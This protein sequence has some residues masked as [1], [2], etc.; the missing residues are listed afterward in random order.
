ML[1]PPVQAD[2]T[3][4]Q[5]RVELEA[6]EPRKLLSVTTPFRGA[7]FNI[8]TDTIEAED[9][10][11]GGEGI[12][13]Y[14]TT[15]QNLL[16]AYRN[17]AVDIG[18]D[19]QASNGFAVGYTAPGEW[20]DYSIDTPLAGTYALKARVACFK[21]GGT[22]HVEI[23]GANVTGAMAVPDTGPW[24]TWQ[25]V[26]S[27]PFALSS[28]AHV[29]RVVMD[30]GGY[31]GNIGDFD[32]FR[33]AAVSPPPPTGSTPFHGAP[34]NIA[35]DSIEAEDFDNGGEGVSYHDTTLQNLLGGYRNTAVDIGA[36]TNASNGFAVGYTAPGEWLDYTIRAPASGTYSLQARVASYRPGGT[37]HVEIDGANVTGAMSVPDTGP[38][39]T[40]Q[41]IVS[42]VFNVVSGTHVM[43]VVMDRGGYWGAIGDFDSFRF[44]PAALPP[45]ST[46]AI[47]LH[48]QQVANSPVPRLE[49]SAVTVGSKL[50]VFGGY[51]ESS[52]NWL[53]TKETDAYDP[54]TNTW[55]R[56]ADM[57]EG[58]TH[59]G[60]ATDGR[61]IYAAG[62]YVSNY[63]TGWQT[64]ATR[65]VWRYDTWTNQWT[66]FVPLPAARSAGGLV[67]L[68]RQ[69][70]YVDGNDI[71]R[72]G[73]TDH[74]V[75]NLDDPNPQWVAST[76]LPFSR[77][78]I[79]ATVLGGKIYVAGGQAG[80][81]DADPAADVLAWD[82]ANPRAWQTIASL[83]QPRSHA[84]A[85]V[86]DGKLVLADGAGPG[87]TILN[88]V[89]AYD[90]ATN[91][92]STVNDPLPAARLNPAGAVVDGR[93]VI[94]TG[95]WSG[96]RS[97]T[98][99]SSLV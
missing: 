79:T 69:I 60:T 27:Q 51:N 53:A 9:F 20:L 5:R 8:S 82:P 78:H 19:P 77:N 92:W 24:D 58:L 94:T 71:N 91:I 22:Y 21:P 43:R 90:P 46:G 73:T 57:P 70:H 7:P 6:L 16:G 67:L 59:I 1:A 13:Y 2:R 85:D 18:A 83:P 14:D 40:W 97:E 38:W 74:W 3:R 76:P 30:R 36:E 26:T 50:Y 84:V 37:F 45:P 4:W 93:L 61:Y 33:F 81:N 23:D 62:G 25:T 47:A 29:M 42:P 86:I 56:L 52:P 80:N 88:S 15:P 10:D 11:N 34:F 87:E 54:A 32:S 95:Y 72:A 64:F 49:A 41:S 12:S 35:T 31:W 55:T 98:W 44:A 89:I 39:D 96:L 65:D 28:G 66:P 63:T 99:V 68:G 75:L 48:W 17:T